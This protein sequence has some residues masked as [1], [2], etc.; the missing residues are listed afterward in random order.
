MDLSTSASIEVGRP[1]R[2]VFDYFTVEFADFLKPWLLYPG[3]TGSI[4]HGGPTSVGSRRTIELS[5]GGVLDETIVR[6]GPG[7]EHS[8]EWTGGVAF[9]NS[10]IVHGG[11]GSW[12]F[13]EV[14]HGTR[15]WFS[16]TFTLTSPLWWPIGRLMMA[17][18]RMWM[19]KGLNRGKARLEAKEIS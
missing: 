17:G 2:Q 6:H 18:Y 7:E 4:V 16:D 12:T 15:V 10:L 5:D 14:F 9:P 3:I 8:Y 13:D 11:A 19:V 1:R